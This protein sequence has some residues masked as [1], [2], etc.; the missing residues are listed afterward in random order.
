MGKPD[1]DDLMF[2]METCYDLASYIKEK[3]PD[4]ML[5]INTLE[6]AAE[7]FDVFINEDTDEEK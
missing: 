7:I 1:K 4:A 5:D 2:A 3:E 6:N